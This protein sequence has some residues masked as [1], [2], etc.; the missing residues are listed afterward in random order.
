ME[1]YYFHSTFL[2]KSCIN[3]IVVLEKTLETLGL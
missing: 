2:T 1:V 3:L